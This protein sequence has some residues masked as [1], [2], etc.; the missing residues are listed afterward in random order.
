MKKNFYQY[1]INNLNNFGEFTINIFIFLPYFFS[2]TNLIKTLFHPWKNIQVKKTSPGF[3]F[4]EFIDIL[5]FNLISRSIGF[6]MRFS[7]IVFY[8][9]FQSFFMFFLPV[10][11]LVYFLLQPLLYLIYLIKKS[12]DEIKNNLKNEF[13]KNHL[14]KE[15]NKKNVEL[16]F[17]KYFDSHL[18][19]RQWWK[20]NNLMSYP[21]LARDWSYGYTPILDQYCQDLTS[22]SYLV[23]LNNI[24]DREKE[25]NEIEL[26]LSKNSESN[27][28][29][30]GEEGVGKHTIIDAFAKKIYSGKTTQQLMYKRILKVN[31]EK[32]N[33]DIN[34]FES[35]LKE[36]Y[37]AK[38]I[39]LFIDNFEK[40]LDLITSFEKFIKSNQL[41]VIA[42]T[43]PFFYQKY[44]YS[45]EIAN[46]L[47]EKV[48]VYEI[49]KNQALN[50]LLEKFSDFENH[51]HVYIPYETLLEIVDKSQFYIT[52][53][54]F[55]EKAIELLDST[56][57]FTKKNDK[58]I[59]FKNYYP[60]VTL[61]NV[62]YVLAEKTHI[63]TIID[64]QLKEKLV[65]LETLLKSEIFDQNEAIN[66]LSSSL[67]RSFL[68]ISKRKKPLA[69]FLFL[70][71][72]GVG[73][74]QTAKAIAQ[75]F[76][77][78]SKSKEN[79]NSNKV[80][81]LIRF[82]MS[83]YQSKYDI[84]KLIGDI[85]TGEPGLLTSAIREQPYGV[86]LL[87][88]LEKADKNL[89]NIFLTIIDEGYF[90]DGFGRRVDCKNL[91]II[92]TSNAKSE[93]DF[94]PEFINRF[95]GVITFN[96][97]TKNALRLIAQKVLDQ[98][99]FDIYQLYKIKVKIKEETINSLIEKGYSLEYGARNLERVIRDEIEDKIAQLIFSD[100][101]KENQIIII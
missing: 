90:T 42:E 17:E 2:I 76:F 23:H 36:A 19:K 3:S 80:S 16:W 37:E 94:P 69:T 77:S 100:K 47:F 35:L 83:N 101:I 40:Y 54:P 66:K 49:N 58:K 74:T 39:I 25:I 96:Q 31:M 45:N 27:V 95:D 51:Y 81:Y 97:L 22:P 71:P 99:I 86:L 82:D 65:N 5:F 64:K 48:D 50:I 72:T 21:P 93:K 60:I 52:Y 59:A 62:N 33:Q 73:K 9:I 89:L 53:I 56:C 14:L 68:M 7:I 24:V 11:A 1:L 75:V 79:L 41:Q 43:T 44:I 61:E 88:E 29:I 85:N 91:V 87:D 78:T 30:V 20:L 18:K 46:R 8:F 32:I 70:G 10:I 92:A 34:F 13:I 98:I 4:S 38:N 6:I 28:I 67:R 12:P 15:E 63:P 55:P 84:P 57:V 26:V